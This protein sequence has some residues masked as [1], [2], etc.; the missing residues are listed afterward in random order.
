MD[1]E[2]GMV[3]TAMGLQDYFRRWIDQKW[4]T[5]DR[6]GVQT[7]VAGPH[8][9]VLLLRTRS[10]PDGVRPGTLKFVKT[11][12]QQHVLTPQAH[13]GDL[14]IFAKSGGTRSS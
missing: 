13:T 5:P 4:P 1:N 2:V 14:D 10:M 7:V 3:Q 9:M 6:V 12:S 11:S 8:R